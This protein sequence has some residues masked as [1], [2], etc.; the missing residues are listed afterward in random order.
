MM[1]PSSLRARLLAFS[2]VMVI[3]ALA[4]S[5]VGLTAIFTRQY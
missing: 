4:L 3:A 1:Q 5:A 2:A